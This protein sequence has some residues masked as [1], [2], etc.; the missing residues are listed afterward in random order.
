MSQAVFI[1]VP[2]HAELA[3][4]A[5]EGLM[6]ATARHRYSVNTEGGSLLALMFNLLSCRCLNQRRERGWTHFAM[7]HA[8]IEAPAGW[9]DTLLD[10]MQ[11]VGADVLSTVV[12]IK[13][14]RGLTS[15]GWQDPDTKRIRRLTMREA[16]GLPVTFSA[17]DLPAAGKPAGQHLM[18]NTGL[19]VCDLGKPWVEEVCFTVRDAVGRLD[20]GRFWPRCV[21]EDWGFSAWCAGR[22]LRVFATRAV[23]VVHH[24]RAGYTNARAWGEWETDR[25][26]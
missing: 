9:A 11:R 25:G 15:T 23:P 26:D 2:H 12:P 22:G 13:D 16:V 19:W 5:L 20:D 18:V 10:E 17:A 7:H 14:N 21:P 1:A 4:Q 24:G 6:L 3:P 8:D